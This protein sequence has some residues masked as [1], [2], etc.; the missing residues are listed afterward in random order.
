MSE[1]KE[2]LKS[3]IENSNLDPE[4]KK[5]WNVFMLGS[6][7]QEDEAVYEAVSESEENLHLLSKYL[8][9]KIRTMIGQNREK[10]ERLVS[11]HNEFAGLF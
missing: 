5:L 6:E 8:E 4:K 3:L 2:K 11:R 10:W 9:D 1:H 7:D